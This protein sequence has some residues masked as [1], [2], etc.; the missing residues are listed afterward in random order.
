MSARR[1]LAASLCLAAPAACLRPSGP[2]QDE[3]RGA[4]RSPAAPAA[5]GARTLDDFESISAWKSE[6]S[7][8]VSAAARQDPGASGQALRLDFD[9]RGHGGYAIARREL[10]LDF[11]GNYEISFDLRGDAPV[12]NLEL[13]L[14]DRSGENVW[15]YR[16]A[17]L[18]F[19]RAWQRIRVKK[20]QIQFAWG[21]TADKE[22]RRSASL[23]LVVSA[24]K[25]GGRGSIW[26][27]RLTMREVPP[28][29]AVPPRPVASASSSQPGAAPALAVDGAPATAWRS[30]RRGPAERFELD[31]GYAR[32][33]GGAIL[34]WQPGAH[35]SRYDV[36]LSQ[37][38]ATWQLARR[39]EGG[40]G[41]R[42]AL[43]LPESE[44]RYLRLTL[45]DGPGA[46]YALAELEVRDLAFGASPNAF[47]SA[48]AADSPRGRY[49][50]GFSG[51]Q[52]YWTIVGV[53]GATQSG[54]FSED[55]ALEIAKGGPSIEPFVVSGE[56]ET[57]TSW[58]D[59]EI[60]QS[61]E[62]GYLPIPRVTWRS[63]AWEL[64]VTAFAGG[65]PERARLGARYELVNRTAK[66]IDAALVLAVRPYQVNPPTQFLNLAGGVSPIRELAWD[67]RALSVNGAPA[68]FPLVRP[69]HVGLGTFDGGGFPDQPAP[70][71]GRAAVK[72]ADSTGMA[73]AALVYRVHLPPH[74]RV[75]VGVAAPLTGASDSPKLP[76]LA[77]MA[78][79]AR[80]QSAVS[81]AWREKLNRF[82]IR[83]PAEGKPVVDTLRSALAQILMTRE[84]PQLQPGTRSY[85]RSWI[86]D[87]AMI[88]ESL[89]RLGHE[90]TA[91]EYLRWYAPHQFA[92][93][94]VPCCVD[95][96]GADPVPENDSPGELIFLAAELY[97][98]TGDRVLLEEMWPH[99]EAAAGYLE[100]MRQSE[101][102]ARN[103]TPA[104]RALYGLLPPSISHEGYSAKP[105]YS[106]WDDFWGLIGYQ[107]ATAIAGALGKGDAE[108]RLA[109]Q[110]DQ[111]RADL[112]A[113][114]RAAAAHHHIKYI[115]GAADLG[116]FDATST[117]IALAPGREG[118]TLPRDLLVP[119]FERYW[120]EHSARVDGSRV[121]DAYTPYELRV[122]GTFVRLGWRERAHELLDF[123]FGHRRP[124]AWNQWA[125]VV[126]RELREPR[127]IGDM[128]H[129]WVASD[130]IRSA[131]DMFAYARDA[132]RTLVL[133]AGLPP[134]WLEAG[135]AVDRL[136]TP[137][138]PLSYSISRSGRRVTMRISGRAPPGGIAFPWPWDGEPGPTTV[139][140]AAA[141]WQSGEL[142]IARLPARI[143]IERP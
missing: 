62:G 97:R 65:A 42:D 11:P 17:D 134:A 121:W 33:L 112:Y 90:K 43:L 3:G 9:F 122:V 1:A 115:P 58:A 2:A 49:P 22:L 69:D 88:S 67:G 18:E 53:E 116:D 14:V 20:R 100:T 35:A 80:L 71:G 41:G 141:A 27:D 19:P 124:V 74:G 40:D 132:D 108:A 95:A 84:G 92:S 15:W 5:H 142:R 39:V 13:K 139:D 8:G 140:G 37:D 123:F 98:F 57:V 109:G 36:E 50:R 52:P 113:S 38:R 94:K 10:P 30:A 110:R 133:A 32:E 138:G 47:V 48:L 64:R 125:E 135:V 73:S 127:F 68:V 23:E 83:V 24:G 99:V 76:G 103:R 72:L 81:A 101:R 31:L 89:L 120:A 114:L 75:A 126:G 26:V 70:S 82:S 79:L 55:G 118:P 63:A 136:R 45:R 44:A 128:P 6:G 102:T 28:P 4:E 104:R 77:S 25:G 87:G 29:P 96:R 119:T 111:F 78:E 16:R 56:P 66:P 91:A 130:Y 131:L 12:N 60:D 107:D 106:Y 105:A 61:L 129:A 137:Y 86:R 46:D 21:P 51:Q 34:R 143:S 93:G 7:D 54:L 117:T 85:S 59:A